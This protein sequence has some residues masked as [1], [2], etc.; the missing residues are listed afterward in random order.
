M[1]G[2]ISNFFQILE[3]EQLN[4]N[5]VQKFRTF[6]VTARVKIDN[7]KL[8]IRLIRKAVSLSSIISFAATMYLVPVYFA[9]YLIF[10]LAAI[11]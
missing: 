8:D 3:A 11:F 7:D 10:L 5:I 1:G 4:F 9:F 6:G 2:Y